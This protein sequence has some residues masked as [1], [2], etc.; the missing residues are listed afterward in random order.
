ND[1]LGTGQLEMD[2]VTV[3][4]SWAGGH[5]FSDGKVQELN[6]KGQGNVESN[7]NFSI[8]RA[9]FARTPGDKAQVKI[10]GYLGEVSSR[11]TNDQDIFTVSLV[12]GEVLK[13]DATPEN[14]A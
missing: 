8:D 1:R 13:L 11:N 12:A 4:T 10:N 2:P 3:R 6:F 7:Q 14:D 9:Q 5:G